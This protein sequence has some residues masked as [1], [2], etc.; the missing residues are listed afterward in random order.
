[1]LEGWYGKI[2][3]AVLGYIIGRGFL[4]AVIGLVLGHQFDSASRRGKSG[5][6]TTSGGAHDDPAALRRTFFEA[7][8]QVMGHVAK[9]DGRVTEAESNAAA[10]TARGVSGVT[11]VVKVFEIITPAELAA[12]TGAAS[13]PASAPAA[14]AAKP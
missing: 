12:M 3:G 10:N 13:T 9:S 11:K 5:R 4:G 2:I 7:T 6:G 8:F 1:M 14:S